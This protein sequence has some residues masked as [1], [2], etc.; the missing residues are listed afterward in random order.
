MIALPREK[1]AA[2]RSG[3]W[4]SG[5][6]VLLVVLA[7]GLVAG[8][9]LRTY[10]EKSEWSS[11]STTIGNYRRLP[12]ADGSTLEL[13]TDTEVRYRLSDQARLLD[14][15][16]GEARFRVA[17]DARRPFVVRARHTVIR[18]E[19]TEFTV[20]IRDNGKV[21]IMVADGVVS[22]SHRRRGSAFSE[23]LHGPAVP[24]EDGT[25]VP[26]KRMV[27]DDDGRL[28]FVEMT[29]AS[30]E[31]HD[32]WRSNMLVF[33][34]TPLREIVEELNRYDRRKLEIAD[35]AIANVLLGGRYR[36]RD[37]EGFIQNLRAV[38]KIRVVEMPA[39][40]GDG[41]VLRIYSE[42]AK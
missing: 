31:A 38:L 1:E 28:A 14:L 7:V 41:T 37:V 2:P 6:V 33:D 19:G 27:T 34:S 30:M 13:N 32:A 21:D 25:A 4:R 22:V 17:H 24:L 40:D 11:V 8:L 5:V 23:L 9:S 26:E 10:S 42:P 12:L 20:R 29:R 39:E 15:T 36:P 16:A 18:A 35:P 3:R